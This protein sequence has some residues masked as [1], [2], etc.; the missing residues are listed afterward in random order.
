MMQRRWSR[1]DGLLIT[2]ILL[3][4]CGTPPAQPGVPPTPT[5]TPLAIIA[6]PGRLA[7]PTRTTLVDRGTAPPSARPTISTAR[8]GDLQLELRL[9]KASFLAGEAGRA[10]VTARNLGSDPVSVFGGCTWAGIQVLDGKGQVHGPPWSSIAMS[11]P[12]A[13]RTIP[14]GEE[15]A[16]TLWFAFPPSGSATRVR[17]HSRQERLPV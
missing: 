11:C 4:A 14:P 12:L 6:S 7:T 13:S 1:Q 15:L 5:P 16:I 3:T 8:Q 17:T 2:L 9:D 10:T